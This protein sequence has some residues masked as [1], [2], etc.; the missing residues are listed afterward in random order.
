MY[1]SPTLHSHSYAE[2]KSRVEALAVGAGAAAT[3]DM[4][5]WFS[6]EATWAEVGGSWGRMKE[7]G[8]GVDGGCTWW[9]LAEV[10]EREGDRSRQREGT[11]GM[12]WHR[13]WGCSRAQRLRM[14]GRGTHEEAQEWAGEL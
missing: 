14:G 2:L 1:P 8:Q 4:E 12:G 10:G 11:G 5:P 9:P 3:T 13:R 7:K 6:M